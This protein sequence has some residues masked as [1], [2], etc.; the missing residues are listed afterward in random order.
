MNKNKIKIKEPNEYEVTYA[1]AIP[2][3][4]SKKDLDIFHDF[5]VQKIND[6]IKEAKRIKWI[7]KF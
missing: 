6:E 4:R 1:H 5:L 7:Q 3:F 2:I